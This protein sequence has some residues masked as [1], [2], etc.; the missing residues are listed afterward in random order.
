MHVV[1]IIPEKN[2][3]SPALGLLVFQSQELSFYFC[4]HL[5]CDLPFVERSSVVW[6]EV[7]V[8]NSSGKMQMLY[9]PV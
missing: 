1:K 4:V 3:N 6:I 7:G 9:F 8:G 2:I 5:G